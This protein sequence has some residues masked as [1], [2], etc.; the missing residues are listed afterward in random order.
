MPAA[1]R[2]GRSS[3]E[4]PGGRARWRPL[5]TSCRF[6][7]VTNSP[8]HE[9]RSSVQ[10]G[11]LLRRSLRALATLCH[12]DG[13]TGPAAGPRRRPGRAGR[14]PA[15]DVDDALRHPAL[16]RSGG[17]VAAEIGLRAAVASAALDG[18]GY[19]LD[20]VRAGTVTDPV[21]QGALRVT[22]ELD[23]MAALWFKV[24]R[25]VLARV[26]V[27]AARDTVASADLGRPRVD[28]VSAPRLAGVFE[29]LASAGTA[30]TLL[31][32]A[33]VHA[34]LLTLDAFAGPGGVLAR[35]AARLTLVGRRPGP[36]RPDRPGDRPPGP[37]TGVRGRP[38]RLR[39]RYPRRPTR[40]AAPLRHR[41]LAGRG[42]GS[43][44]G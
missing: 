13:S 20:E 31:R 10:P 21:V 2:S 39:H 40:L 33:V 9:T 34:E 6:S 5:L 11:A 7:C 1:T 30:P 12:H 23:S 14:R 16:R 44:R 25:Q 28:P 3:A 27:L 26:H 18:H 8:T 24:P 35:A 22:R 36:A 37:A 15:R 4:R 32:A 41:R 38:R 42:G 19:P 43:H 17:R 29:L